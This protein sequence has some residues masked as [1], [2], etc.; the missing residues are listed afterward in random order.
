MVIVVPTIGATDIVVT[1][2][3]HTTAR[4]MEGITGRITEAIMEATGIRIIG[5]P[6]L[7][8]GSAFDV[9]ASS[10]PL[11]TLA[12]PRSLAQP[13][14]RQAWPSRLLNPDREHARAHRSK[15]QVLAH[16]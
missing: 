4:T 11:R 10:S 7:V 12:E 9:A 2:I 1:A 15:A 5:V 3:D 16:N 14:A 8:C 6:A 13:D